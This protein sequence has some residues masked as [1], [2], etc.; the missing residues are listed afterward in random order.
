MSER[1][2]GKTGNVDKVEIYPLQRAGVE[3][4]KTPEKALVRPMK[5]FHGG[6]RQPPGMTTKGAQPRSSILGS[7]G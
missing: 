7:R 3:E 5:A 6:M 4:G 2:N 1:I